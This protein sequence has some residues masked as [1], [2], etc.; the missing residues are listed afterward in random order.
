MEGASVQD[1]PDGLLRI[2]DCLDADGRIALP[3]GVTLISLI[4]RNIAHVG[5]SVAY[6]Y[7]DHTGAG[8]GTVTELTWA[9]LGVRL[10][11]VGAEVQ[12]RSARGD[13]VAV[14]APQGL[15]Y[16]TGFFA[17]IKAG[18]IAVPLFAP[19][20]Q[21]HAQRLETALRDARPSLVLTTSAAADAVA[22]F[23]ADLTGV[24]TP[25][26]VLIDEIPDSAAVDFVDTVVDVDDV[27][28]LQYTSG[29]TRPPAGVEITHRAVGTNLLQMIL[30]IDLLDRNT[31]GVS[32]LPL[33]HDMGLSMIGFPAVYGGHSTLMSPTAFLRR[34][35][36][37]IRA[38]SDESRQGRVV[39][40]APNFAY[41]WTA[42]R[43][44]PG[45]DD[46]VD[47]ANVV[48][49]V[50][51]EPVSMAAIEE[52]NAAFGPYGLPATAFKPSY[53]IAEATLFVATIAPSERA[54]ALA[55]DLGEL[56]AGRLVP[57][58]GADAVELVSC[59]QIA[60]SQWAVIVEPESGNELP[61]AQIG[62]IWL[63]GDNIGRGYWGQPEA[64]AASFR[65]RLGSRL[66]AGSHADGVPPD[67]RWLRTGDLG[68]YLDGELYVTGRMADL[69]IVDG[70]A[71]YPQHIEATAA[72]ASALVRRGYAAAF[73]VPAANGVEVVIVAERAPGT[74]G[75]DPGAAVAAIR[76][77][78][79]E[80]HGPT[81]AQVRFV[82]AGSIP[83]TTSGKLAR[84]AC[85]D[86]YR[87]V[88]SDR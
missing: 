85:R 5:D 65:A 72:D 23:L 21:G 58:A 54:T 68:A 17:A 30:A 32:W 15:D 56:G 74:R 75:A 7:I 36:R 51:S 78:V 3:P 31:H 45:P 86:E 46:D 29:A 83:R 40:A 87:S 28:H 35:Q 25:Q 52:F 50:G 44:R 66:T 8:D 6:R 2:E 41:E 38:L 73:T 9:R 76:A 34:P 33:F 84:R 49:I 79:A 82:P 61:D 13:R 81:V 10:R 11:A 1:V 80:R 63:H 64:T 62:E 59:G 67:G 39:T 27:S 22:H 48:L 57:A 53:G 47:L 69:L 26:M 42:E 37:W 19:E 24:P 43:G 55:V 60:N 12:R 16:I 88:V 20:L 14:L 18:A 70:R 4:D 77:A 71:H